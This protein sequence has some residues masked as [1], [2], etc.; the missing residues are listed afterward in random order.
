MNDILNAIFDKFD[1]QFKTNI[2]STL[3]HTLVD[4][5]LVGKE[6]TYTVITGGDHGME[7]GIAERDSKGYTPSGVFFNTTNWDKAKSIAEEINK[8]AFGQD[9]KESYNI[10]LSSM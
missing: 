2:H 4:G 8:M 1:A 5:E 9:P 6:I 7:I 10:V 3:W